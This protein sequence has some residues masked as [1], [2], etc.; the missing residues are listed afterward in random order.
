MSTPSPA[1]PSSWITFWGKAHPELGGVAAMHPVVAHSLDVAAV[2]MLLPRPVS[3]SIPRHTL[4]FLVALHDIGKFSKP[5]QAIAP[6]HWP[7]ALG[8]IP[9][10]PPGGP[11]HDVLSLRLLQDAASQQLDIV[12][13]PRKNGVR[14]WTE[15]DRVHLLQA[16]AG[17]HGRPVTPYEGPAS[18]HLC[19]VCL[20]AA[21]DFAA[22][23][24]DLFRPPPLP[25]PRGAMAAAQLGWDLAGV[26]TLADWIGSRQAWFPYATIQQASDPAAYFWNFALPRAAAALA[27]AGMSIA[28]AA[29]FRG[30]TRLFPR[31]TQSSPVQVWA[32]TTSLPPGPLLA[33]IEDVTGSGKT[34][35]A[36]V[37]AHRLMASGRAEGVFFALPT[38]ATANAMF[39]RMADAYRG[40]FSAEANPSLVLAHGRAAL[41]PRFAAMMTSDP[42]APPASGDDPADIPAEAHCAAWLTED[43]RRALLAQIGVGTID[44]ALLAI[45]PVRHAVL[46]LQ[47]LKGKVLVVDEAHA[48]DP[49]MQRELVELLR[50]HAALGGSA[51]L[52]SATLPH[53]VRQR[54]TD[55]FRSGLGQAPKPLCSTA[56]PLATLAAA[57]HVCE[58]PCEIRDGLARTVVVSRMPDADAAVARIVAAAH[59]GAAVAWVRNTVDDAIAAVQMLRAHGLEPLLLFHAR[60]AMTDR[61]T[62]EQEVLRRFGRTSDG[63]GRRCVLVA[64]QVI[65][66]SL[67]IDFDLLCTDLAPADLLI[68]RAGR[69]WRHDRPRPPATSAPE[70]LVISPDPVDD[71]PT[72]WISAPQPGTEAV[73]RDPALL[74]RSARA[75]F[76]AGAIT[77]PTD[78]RPL[79]EAA[80]GSDVPAAL[81][82]KTARAEGKALGEAG[83]ARQNVLSFKDGYTRQNGDWGP[84]AITPTRLEDQPHVTLRLA[85][86]RDGVVVPYAEHG[87]LRVAWSLSEV[88]V[89]Q[90]HAATCPPQTGLERAVAAAR[91]QWGR[92]ERD[93]LNILLAVMTPSID[94]YTM[95][96]TTKEGAATALRYDRDHGLV[97]K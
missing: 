90:R 30:L 91:A 5:F 10:T 3:C 60:F 32:Q 72:D 18:S 14:G 74:W 35:A 75:V 68:Q 59:E 21:Q 39:G 71:P 6:N 77:T 23:M 28:P 38:M 73:Y 85:V 78:M 63:E 53:A 9:T 76:A 51:I 43:R 95:S 33:V 17:H 94:G 83:R 66:Q 92:W 40:L 49:Y 62:I 64:T 8:A 34:E 55:A 89:A 4:G 42:S 2:A 58:T 87:D 16:L 61:L 56:Y 22:A 44:Q 19:P 48:F 27:A 96:V 37:L 25:L 24:L 80:G 26:V 13:P 65:E 12:L 15:R 45:L 11:R 31:I 52:L 67:D 54:L 46:R 81:A 41:D 93:S 79:I 88:S 86:L 82:P 20:L 29:P 50:F 84:D 97:F 69:L 7:A 47:G 1:S 57:D 36:V 70:L